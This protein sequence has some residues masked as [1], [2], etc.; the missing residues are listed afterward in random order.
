MGVRGHIGKFLS[1]R[2][3]RQDADMWIAHVGN[4]GKARVRGMISF[5][6]HG[7]YKPQ[8]RYQLGVDDVDEAYGGGLAD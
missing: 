7:S 4:S 8:T 2:S 5:H 6:P 3:C 1:F